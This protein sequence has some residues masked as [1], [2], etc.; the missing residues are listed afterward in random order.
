MS[1]G[2]SMQF[3]LNIAQQQ[4]QW[5]ELVDRVSLAEELGFTGAWIFDHFKP[6]SGDP[7]GPCLEG[8][9]LLAGLAAMTER[10]RLG[11]LVT[12]VTYRHPSVL[13][14]EAMTVDHI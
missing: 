13:A 14:A 6:L 4:L 9:T 1:Q 8:W 11:I 12:G 7:D 5:H 2:E 3:G 10:I